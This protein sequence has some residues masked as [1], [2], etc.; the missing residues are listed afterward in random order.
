M[1]VNYFARY[2]FNNDL[3]F[4]EEDFGQRGL[5]VETGSLSAVDDP[6]YGKALS[7]DGVSL[8]ATGEFD[9]VTDDSNRSICFWAKNSSSPSPVFAL[10]SLVGPNG[11][12]FYT[13]NAAGRPEFYNHTTRYEA[14]DEVSADTWHSYAVTYD[15]AMG[16]LTMFVD[17]AH[18]YTA[19]VGVLSTG[20]SESLRIGTDGE[21]QFFTGQLLDFRIWDT[22]LSAEVVLYMHEK[23]PNFEEPLPTK[24]VSNTLR[25]ETIAGSLLCKT[26]VGIK[27][28]G[29][30]LYDSSYAHSANFDVL[31][32]ARVEYAQNSSG[33]GV[34]T[35]KVRHAAD[36]NT[37]MA[38]TVKVA[39]EATTFTARDMVD[40][41]P[42][43]VIFSSEGVKL[44]PSSA[45]S[46]KGC[47]VFGKGA[48]FRIR[49]KDGLFT[50]EAYSSVG[51]KYVTK[52]E[53]GA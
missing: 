25:T 20:S 10:G 39:P 30:V 51:D 12:T 17:G 34:V 36:A 9:H 13:R 3:D 7:I 42:S 33:N 46:E 27:P 4:G 48:D 6:A 45:S 23:G 53:I 29:E 38:E 22:T 15:A 21:G 35:L 16:V 40:D 31:E 24:Y 41:T 26:N 2:R 1:S 52:M 8:L 14:I 32:A 44:V 19:T 11:F 18:F 5:A 50:V 47:L 43:S 28:Y 37:E 49:V